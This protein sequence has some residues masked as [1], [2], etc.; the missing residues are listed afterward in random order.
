[1][2]QYSTQI[3]TVFLHSPGLYTSDSFFLS[4]ICCRTT[5]CMQSR[6]PNPKAI[7]VQKTP[8]APGKQSS[9]CAKETPCSLNVR[10]T[11]CL[12]AVVV[13]RAPV[14]GRA[15]HYH[16]SSAPS[17]CISEREK[18]ARHTVFRFPLGA[19]GVVPCEVCVG[20]VV[21]F[22]DGQF[23]R[24]ADGGEGEGEEGE[25]GEEVHFGG[26]G[27]C[28]CVRGGL[29]LDVDVLRRARCRVVMDGG[30]ARVGRK[31]W[32]RRKVGKW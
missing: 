31:R 23:H 7:H 8:P 24:C 32:N 28:G 19:H 30:E 11:H 2:L 29:G 13:V 17:L 12:L 20:R 15:F 3:C 21:V 9:K 1:M 16:R 25:G 26:E 6:H 22:G 10:P 14:Q 5:G 4:H 18:R 27:L